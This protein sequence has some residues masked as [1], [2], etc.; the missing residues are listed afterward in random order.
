MPDTASGYQ[1]AL[2]WEVGVQVAQPEDIQPSQTHVGKREDLS[3]AD[4]SYLLDRGRFARRAIC[5]YSFRAP[6]VTSVYSLAFRPGGL[7]LNVS[8]EQ[9][10]VAQ[11]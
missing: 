6:A 2:A 9:T 8:D 11:G 5:T 3:L 10:S 4:C 1:R 7:K